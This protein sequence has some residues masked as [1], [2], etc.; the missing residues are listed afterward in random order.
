MCSCCCSDHNAL[1]LTEFRKVP[2]I[3]SVMNAHRRN[4]KR[5]GAV[6]EQVDVSC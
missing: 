4:A 2:L 5:S 6:L 1:V 3:Q